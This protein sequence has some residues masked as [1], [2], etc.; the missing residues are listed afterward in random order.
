MELQVTT[1]LLIS[2]RLPRIWQCHSLFHCHLPYCEHY[3][4]RWLTGYIRPE[5]LRAGCK[6][7]RD[8]LYS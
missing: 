3:L 5:I 7:G 4:G 2:G 8:R 1:D 6:R